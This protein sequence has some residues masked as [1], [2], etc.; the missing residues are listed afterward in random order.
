MLKVVKIR[1]YP[2]AQQQQSLAQAFGSCRWLWNYFLNLM[3]ETYKETGKG[4]SG[5]EVKKIIPQLKKEHEWLSSTYSQCLQKVCLNL[6]VAFNNFFEKRAKYPK[7]KSKHGKQSIQY[8]Q[9]VKITD[10]QLILP[11]IGKVSAMMK[12]KKN[13]DN[14]SN[15][16]HNNFV[17]SKDKYQNKDIYSKINFILKILYNIFK[18]YLIQFK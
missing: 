16:H 12:I 13:L 17:Q 3:N 6:G 14:A 7:F 10:N 11:K 4:L 5:Y 18:E 1:L 9:N 8:P 2:D 15:I